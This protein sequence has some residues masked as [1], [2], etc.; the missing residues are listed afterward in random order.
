MADWMCFQMRGVSGSRG[1][2]VR[3][4]GMRRRFIRIVLAL[5][6][7]IRQAPM[8]AMARC[9]WCA[10]FGRSGAGDAIKAEAAKAG[11]TVDY[12]L[13]P[14]FYRDARCAY[15]SPSYLGSG[16][17]SVMPWLGWMAASK[18]GGE[19]AKRVSVLRAKRP[20]TPAC[21]TAMSLHVQA[22]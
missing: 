14:L 4:V 9:L 2:A 7:Q 3:K 20:G 22:L 18:L 11:R 8:S 1:S 17:L 19:A 6:F 12:T 16:R 10:C 13:W 21:P 15:C 5:H